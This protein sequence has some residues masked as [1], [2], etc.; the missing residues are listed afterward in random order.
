MLVD[1]N[2]GNVSL[3][4]TSSTLNIY[5]A[6]VERFRRLIPYM[7]FYFT[8]QSLADNKLVP[9]LRSQNRVPESP[10]TQAPTNL[11]HLP[12]FNSLTTI[13]ATPDPR[14]D[15]LAQILNILQQAYEPGGIDGEQRTLTRILNLLHRYY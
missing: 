1:R 7:T 8:Q 15:T 10:I 13:D 2:L 12:N 11:E 14:T 3:N 9:N 4:K 6:S 5:P